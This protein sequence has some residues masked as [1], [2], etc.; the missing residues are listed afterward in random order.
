MPLLKQLVYAFNAC[1]TTVSSCLLYI[2]MA[3][4]WRQETDVIS[5]LSG[6]AAYRHVRR[7][8]YSHILFENHKIDL[9][10]TTD[11]RTWYYLSL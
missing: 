5:A 2:P 6:P 3:R 11:A 4:H 9:V 10:S 7:Q 1:S 8:T